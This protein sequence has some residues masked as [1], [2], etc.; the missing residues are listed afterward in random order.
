MPH[1]HAELA[2]Y[3]ADDIRGWLIDLDGTLVCGDR[4]MPGATTFLD[5]CAGRFVVVSNDAEHTPGEL[6]RRLKQMGL[7]VPANRIVGLR[8][9]AGRNP[10][11]D[12]DPQWSIERQRSAGD[13]ARFRHEGRLL[14]QAI[15]LR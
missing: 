14:R 15:I 2:V 13:A 12:A 6:A 9:T 8:L 5:A 3:A 4:V 11:I 1:F 10:Q 7:K